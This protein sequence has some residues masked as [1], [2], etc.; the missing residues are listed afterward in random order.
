MAF[1]KKKEVIFKVTKNG[2][3]ASLG[4]HNKWLDFGDLDLI[5]KVMRIIL[6]YEVGGRHVS[7]WKLPLVCSDIFVPGLDA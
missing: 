3:D 7:F 4:V 5:F 1:V 2:T 6:L